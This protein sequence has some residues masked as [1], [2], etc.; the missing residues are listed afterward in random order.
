M[1]NDLSLS[2][3]F[4]VA[5]DFDV[6]VSFFVIDILAGGFSGSVVVVVVDSDLFV[7]PPAHAPRSAIAIKRLILMGD[8]PGVLKLRAVRAYL[9]ANCFCKTNYSS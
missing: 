8:S 6:V 9:S 3:L 5:V 2:E 7:H 1:G 4:F